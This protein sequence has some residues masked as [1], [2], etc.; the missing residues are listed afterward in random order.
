MSDVSNVLVK[1]AHALRTI[2]QHELADVVV[3]L[4]LLA[5][6]EEIAAARRAILLIRRANQLQTARHAIAVDNTGNPENRNGR[7]A[8][9]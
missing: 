8:S 1:A 9:R 2:S 3:L 4:A 6:A 5:S 7:S